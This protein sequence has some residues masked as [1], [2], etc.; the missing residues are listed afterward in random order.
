MGAVND[1][2][3]I[4]NDT[5]LGSLNVE[6]DR[7][8]QILDAQAEQ[9]YTFILNGTEYLEMAK[10]P[11]YKGLIFDRNGLIT[12]SIHFKKFNYDHYEEVE[13]SRKNMPSEIWIA[14]PFRKKGEKI[15]PIT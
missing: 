4:E 10:Q 9:N 13:I 12:N 11:R 14:G 15:W 3:I 6:Y 5:L 7:L 8:F 2:L 1:T